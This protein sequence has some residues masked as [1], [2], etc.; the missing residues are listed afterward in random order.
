MKASTV[1][2]SK[3][4]LFTIGFFLF[5]TT[6]SQD[7]KIADSLKKVLIQNDLVDSIQLELLRNLTFHERDVE[8]GL[9]YA[10]QLIQKAEVLQSDKYIFYGLLQKG[11]K[12]WYRGNLDEAL[13]LFIN[14]IEYARRA[15]FRKGEGTALGAIASIYTTSGQHENAM[16]YYREA[17]S[18]LE[19]SDDPIALAGTILNAG[20][21]YLTI[22]EYDSALRYFRKSGAIYDSLSHQIGSAY[23]AGNIGMVY[24]NLGDNDLAEQNINKAID[25][26]EE[27]GDFYPVCFYLL[28]MADIFSDREDLQEAMAY[29]QRSLDLAIAYKLKQQISDAHQKLSELFESTGD[30]GQ[31]LQHY[32]DFVAYRDSVTNLETVQKMA[33]QR[34]EFEVNLREVEI[35]SLEKDRALQQ[36]Y[37]ITAISLFFLSL[38]ILLYLRQ[39]LHNTRLRAAAEQKEHDIQVKDLLKSQETK[40][41]QAMVQGK[42][43]E[44]QHLAKELHNHLGS[45]LATVKVNLNGLDSED[46]SK[47]KTIIELVDQATQDVRNI[48]HELNIGISD[49]FGLL[50]ALKELVQHLQHANKL[51]V[52]LSADLELVRIDSQNEILIYRIVQELVSNVLKHAKASKLSISLTGFEEGNLVN[53]LIEDDG[54]GFD[55]DKLDK[56]ITG[57]GLASLKEMIHKLDGDMNI[58]SSPQGGTTINIDLALAIP[59]NTI[60]L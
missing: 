8:L 49:G 16:K 9:E 38:V 36:T 3:A 24:A 43:E 13:K 28:S 32:K 39:R 25:I 11:Y 27:M 12:I 18:V 17:I 50:P 2:L 35:D 58:D 33:D 15:E 60:E 10:D 57:M 42:E 53:I 34:T 45:L 22:A 44:R 23:N 30:A 4:I 29:A 21:A 41:L 26:L 55:P 48:S 40:A 14:S 46:R 54:Q 59:E 47:Q 37:I 56:D 51:E 31:S 1:I 5:A 7:Q 20:D 52:V 19:K 6:Y